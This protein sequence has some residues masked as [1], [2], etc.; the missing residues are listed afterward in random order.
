MKYSLYESFYIM[1]V[2]EVKFEIL[3]L[4]LLLYILLITNLHVIGYV[5]D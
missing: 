1:V 4:S 5:S 3:L 2:N